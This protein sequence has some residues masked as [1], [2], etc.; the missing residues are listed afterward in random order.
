MQR[1]QELTTHLSALPEDAETDWQQHWQPIEQALEQGELIQARNLLTDFA[2]QEQSK[3]DQAQEHND[4]DAQERQPM[5]MRYA[6][7]LLCWNSNT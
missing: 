1:I 2:Q 4:K 6:V 3:F 7:M 5:P